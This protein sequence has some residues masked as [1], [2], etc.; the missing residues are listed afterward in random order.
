MITVE[1]YWSGDGDELAPNKAIELRVY[2]ETQELC[3]RYSL[4]HILMYRG[5]TDGFKIVAIG[6]ILYTLLEAAVISKRDEPE[7]A[8]MLNNALTFI[9]RVT[10]GDGFTKRSFQTVEGASHKALVCTRETDWKKD[11]VDFSE[12]L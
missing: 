10:S 2:T 3:Q 11:V 9:L 5:G 6:N 12:E 7:L 8:S 1:S 4:H